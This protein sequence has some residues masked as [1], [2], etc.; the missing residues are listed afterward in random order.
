MIK[1]NWHR[2][3]SVTILESCAHFQDRR[4]IITEMSLSA[5]G[6]RYRCT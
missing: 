1:S 3:V 5:Y 4:L 6:A 2:G